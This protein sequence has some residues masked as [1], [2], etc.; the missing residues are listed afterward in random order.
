[1]RIF[2]GAMVALGLGLSACGTADSTGVPACP[3]TAIISDASRLVQSAQATAGV[4][5]GAAQ[6]ASL[7][8]RIT[9]ISGECVYPK[10]K[11]SVTVNMIL[12][13]E[14]RRG[15]ETAAAANAPIG[16]FV[17]IVDS[18]QRVLGR[19]EF[20]SALEFKSGSRQ[21]AVVEELEQKIPLPAGRAAASYDVLVGF[22][23]T[24]E[25]VNLNRASL[26]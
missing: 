19:A 26:R 4:P 6:A 12:T 24:A 20:A 13:I 1:M 18:D 14:G 16:Y 23:L 8:A 17:A 25:Q 10:N 3:R 5:A 7:E 2:V 22:L 15:A 9:R 21:A 11:S